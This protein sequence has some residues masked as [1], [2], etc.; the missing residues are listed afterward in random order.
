MFIRQKALPERLP[1]SRELFWMLRCVGIHPIVWSTDRF[2]ISGYGFVCLHFLFAIYCMRNSLM[3]LLMDDP[4]L[5]LIKGST[6][7]IGSNMR[8]LMAILGLLAFITT[9]AF[10]LVFLRGR[11][12]AAVVFNEL[13]HLWLM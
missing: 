7:P 11:K 8:S 9:L 13:N 2:V 5:P 1:G 12:Q 3:F 6:S 4:V 10:E